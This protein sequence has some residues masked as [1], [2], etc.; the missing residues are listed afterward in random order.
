MRL[1]RLIAIT[2][3]VL[4]A[5]CADLKEIVNLAVAIQQQYKAPVNVNIHNKSHLVITFQNAPQGAVK[6]DNSERA[7][8]AREVAKFAITHYKK[9]ADLEDVTIAF[10]DVSSNGP[11]TITRTERPYTFSIGELK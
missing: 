8:L 10:A 11:V 2:A 1:L 6:A 5:G 3:A 7:G 4:L 9:A